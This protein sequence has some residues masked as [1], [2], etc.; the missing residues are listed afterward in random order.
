MYRTGMLGTERWYGKMRI[1]RVRVY[2]KNIFIPVKPSQI[3][4][5][6]MCYGILLRDARVPVLALVVLLVLQVVP[7]WFRFPLL[8]GT[9]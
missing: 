6:S 5:Y 3:I 9:R 7:V 2:R 4:Q 8:Y 1:V